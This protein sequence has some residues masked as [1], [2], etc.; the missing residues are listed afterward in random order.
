MRINKLELEV[1]PPVV[2]YLTANDVTLMQAFLT[3]FG[4]VFNDLS[5][6]TNNRPST[7]YL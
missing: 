6:H 5:I 2:R 4:E 1:I 3:T 7:S